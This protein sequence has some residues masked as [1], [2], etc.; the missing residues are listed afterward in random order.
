MRKFR[1]SNKVKV[2]VHIYIKVN[3]IKKIA[4]LYKF[5]VKFTSKTILLLIVVYFKIY[6]KLNNLENIQLA[7]KVLYIKEQSKSLQF[8]SFSR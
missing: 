1:L 3:I 8:I 5:S 4:H 6:F 2:P 7:Y